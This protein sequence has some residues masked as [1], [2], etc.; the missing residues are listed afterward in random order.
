MLEIWGEE[1]LD[2]YQG[3]ILDRC[4]EGDGLRYV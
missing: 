2:G 1:G 3:R 4:V